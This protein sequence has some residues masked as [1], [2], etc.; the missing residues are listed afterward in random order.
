MAVPPFNSNNLLIKPTYDVSFYGE[1]KIL[2]LATDTLTL[3]SIT[4][5]QLD[6]LLQTDPIGTGVAHMDDYARLVSDVDTL[7]I[8]HEGDGVR[9]SRRYEWL[10]DMSAFV[11][12][13]DLVFCVALDVTAFTSGAHSVDSVTVTITERTVDG[14]VVQEI[15]TATKATGMTDIAAVETKAVVM[16]FEA[17]K[18]FKITQGNVVAVRIVFNSTDTLTATSF[19]GIMPLYYFQEGSLLK[20]MAESQLILHLHPSLDHAQIVLRDESIQEGL[21]YDGVN[22]QG[23]NRSAIGVGAPLHVHDKPPLLEFF[24]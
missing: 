12:K 23:E 19:E 24:K 14:N 9:F 17:N 15:L 1:D 2:T 5:S 10:S 20:M 13:F 16:H 7:G 6:E 3:Q 4:W 18:P 21:D 8:A 22:R 11:Y